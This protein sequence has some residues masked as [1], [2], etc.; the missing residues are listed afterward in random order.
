MTSSSMRMTRVVTA[1][2]VEIQVKRE[3]TFSPGDEVFRDIVQQIA[4]AARLPDFSTTRYE[5]AVA[6]AKTSARI[7][8]PYQDVLTWARQLGSAT[9]FME[10]INRAG[11]ANDTMRTFV[12]TFRT[13]LQ[14]A[15]A[16]HDDET[17]RALLRRFQ[18]LVCAASITFAGSDNYF[19]RRRVSKG[20]SSTTWRHSVIVVGR[21]VAVESVSA[22]APAGA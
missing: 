9:T 13:R 7:A 16:P 19:C 6:T 17:V 21:S 10:R 4:A 14:E 2:V 18:I 20:V 8:G 5:L 11:S 1:A 15:G 22:G 3:V 12:G